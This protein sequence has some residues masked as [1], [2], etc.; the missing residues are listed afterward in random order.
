MSQL[1]N[2]YLQKTEFEKGKWVIHVESHR[3]E[4]PVDV[5]NAPFVSTPALRGKRR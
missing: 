4:P 2:V 1:S 5:R 3:A